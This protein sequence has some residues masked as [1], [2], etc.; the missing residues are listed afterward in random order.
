M[1]ALLRLAFNV[2]QTISYICGM[3]NLLYFVFIDYMQYK[4][5]YLSAALHKDT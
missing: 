1:N 4:V 3:G 5:F 2:F